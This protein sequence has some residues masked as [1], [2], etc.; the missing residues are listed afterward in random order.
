MKHKG[1]GKIHDLKKMITTIVLPP[2]NATCSES[3]KGKSTVPEGTGKYNPRT[4][5]DT[6]MIDRISFNTISTI[7]VAVIM[8]SPNLY[9][10]YH[11]L[12]PIHRR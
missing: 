10:L 2:F 1:N 11:Q 9:S 8:Q 3:I 6:G 12:Q 5:V 7:C 4:Q